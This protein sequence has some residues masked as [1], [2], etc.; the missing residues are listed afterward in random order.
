MIRTSVRSSELKSIGYSPKERILEVEFNSGG[1]YQYDFVPF[2]IH[3][4]LMSAQSHGKYFNGHI[5]G[6]YHSRKIFNR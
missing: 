1:V 2:E 3:N 6:K 4:A 5:K